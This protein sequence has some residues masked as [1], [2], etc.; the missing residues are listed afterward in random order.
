M[1]KLTEIAMFGLIPLALTLAFTGLCDLGFCSDEK[2]GDTIKES[3]KAESNVTTVDD[4]SFK[5]EVLASKKPVL[6]DFY[7]DWCPPCRKQAPIFD[8]FAKEYKDQVKFVKLNV[9][10]GKKVSTENA[11]LSIPT[12]ILFDKGKTVATSVGYHSEDRMQ[13][14]LNQNLGVKSD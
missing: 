11:I 3:K 6:V 7:A 14:F 10:K 4:S 1:K 13:T 5:K 2:G 12:L 8:A 9:D